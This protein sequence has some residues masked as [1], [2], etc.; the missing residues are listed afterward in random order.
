MLP[1]GF[2]PSHPLVG[3]NASQNCHALGAEHKSRDRVAVDPKPEYRRHLAEP[4]SRVSEPSAFRG[5]FVVHRLFCAAHRA[6]VVGAARA[7]VA[8]E[9][10]IGY[11]RPSEVPHR[12]S[13]MC[14]SE[15]AHRVEKGGGVVRL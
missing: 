5:G 8:V 11:A 13:P 14:P 6:F 4:P 7:R 1:W 12:R 15:R 9:Q 2:R 10:A 3:A